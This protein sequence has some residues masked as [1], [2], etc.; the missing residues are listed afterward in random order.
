MGF[1]ISYTYDGAGNRVTKTEVAGSTSVVTTYTYD[2]AHRVQTANRAG[3]ITTY[4][5]DAAGNPPPPGHPRTP[6]PGP[7]RI[8]FPFRDHAGCLLPTQGQNAVQCGP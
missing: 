6:P 7:G 1:D 3:Q 5:Y 4:Q 8:D 2:A